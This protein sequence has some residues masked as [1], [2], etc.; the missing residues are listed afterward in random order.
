M[1]APGTKVKS[2]RTEM[3]S[4]T[5]V[6]TNVNAASVAHVGVR[7]LNGS[8]PAESDSSGDEYTRADSPGTSTGSSPKEEHLD[9]FMKKF[10]INGVYKV[11]PWNPTTLTSG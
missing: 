7:T 1:D 4:D 10:T 6:K 5:A 9:Q 8:E 3:K 2:G 11:S